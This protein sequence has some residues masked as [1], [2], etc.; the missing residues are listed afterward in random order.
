MTARIFL[1]GLLFLPMGAVAQWRYQAGPMVGVQYT[2]LYSDLFTTAS[3]RVAP[4]VGCAFVVS[5]HPRWEVG[6][7]VVLTEGGAHA[8]AVYFQAGRPPENHLYTYKFYSFETTLYTGWRP[9][10]NLPL[11]LQ[12]G[13]FLGANFDHLNR[14]Q[15]ELMIG[16]YENI[17]QA[18][19]AVNLNDAFSGLDYGLAGGIALGEGQFRAAARY[20]MGLKNLYNYLDFIAHDASFI[21]TAMLRCSLTYYLK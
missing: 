21:Q 20:Y 16:D 19:R 11:W 3:G 10:R 7:E 15:R 18:T 1:L 17:N 8:R 14:Q 5:P 6:Q 4:A 9:A 2:L 12:G 13:G